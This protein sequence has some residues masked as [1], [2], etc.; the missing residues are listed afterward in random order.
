MA[1]SGILEIKKA[2]QVEAL[3]LLSSKDGFRKCNVILT[4]CPMY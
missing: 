3:F 1:D 4:E 2:P